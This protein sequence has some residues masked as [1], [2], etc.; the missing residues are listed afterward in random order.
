MLPG[1]GN[2]ESEGN[3]DDRKVWKPVENHD[4]IE[5]E[6]ECMAMTLLWFS[7]DCVYYIDNNIIQKRRYKGSPTAEMLNE[8][9]HFLSVLASMGY[10]P[11]ESFLEK[12]LTEYTGHPY[13]DLM[14][15]VKDRVLRNKV[16]RE[17]RQADEDSAKWNEL[18][19]KFSGV[20]TGLDRKFLNVHPNGFSVRILTRQLPYEQLKRFVENNQKEL[21][22][23]CTEEVKAVQRFINKIGDLNYYT[24][25]E[26]LVLRTAEIEVF[27]DV[28]KERGTGVT[29][30]NINDETEI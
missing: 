8:T 26:L 11:R 18:K 10:T 7:P 14:A 15:E 19:A 24:V 20:I 12:L 27:Y 22:L 16:Q 29:I 3:H 6:S 28:K 4:M 2:W 9:D 25:T 30:A 21:I 13:S 5:A 17:L 23:W 1:Q